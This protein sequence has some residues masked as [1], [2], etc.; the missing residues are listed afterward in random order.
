MSRSMVANYL[1]L[2]WLLIKT[3]ISTALSYPISFWTQVI[4]IFFNDSAYL[5]LWIVFFKRFPVIA[6]WN[7]DQMMI[8]LALLNVVFCLCEVPADGIFNLSQYV[9]TGQLDSY[10]T[11]PNNI[12]WSVAMSQTEIGAIGDGLFGIVLMFIVYGFAPLKILWFLIIAVLTA[13]LVFNWGLM[14]QSLAFWFGDIEDIARRLM[15]MIFSFSI[16]PQSIFVG[17]IKIIMMTVIPAFYVVTVPVSLLLNFTL[18]YFAILVSSVVVTTL[19]SQ[20]IFYQGLARYESGSL[21][22]FRQ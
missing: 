22:T 2:S 19:A 14:V 12:I 13:V 17:A 20:W 18:G 16:Y 9:V 7:I 5:V 15:R 6:G 3:N 10:L 4:G 21:S 8:L 11:M 1:Q